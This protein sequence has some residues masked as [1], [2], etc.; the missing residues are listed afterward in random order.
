MSYRPKYLGHLNLYVQDVERAEKFYSDILGL[1]TYGRRPGHSV[2]M[3]ADMEQAHEIALMKVRDGAPGPIK[4]QVGLNHMAWKMETFEDLKEIHARL[5]EKG[6][7]IEDVA[8]TTV[9]PW[10]STFGTPTATV[11][12]STMS[13]RGRNG[14]MG[15]LTARVR[16][17]PSASSPGASDTRRLE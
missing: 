10:A 15:L 5:K 1:H 7:P 13:C 4:G 11:S 8:E 17:C 6:V 16:S 14:P 2:F 3:S 9:P 12:R